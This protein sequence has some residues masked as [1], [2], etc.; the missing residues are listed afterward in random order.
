[1]ADQELVA[2][3]TARPRPYVHEVITSA[4]DSGR[5]EDRIEL[6]AVPGV[7]AVQQPPGRRHRSDRAGA[8]A[9]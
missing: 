9:W 8:P 1:M 4:R 5:L 6:A 7:D 2:I 3:A